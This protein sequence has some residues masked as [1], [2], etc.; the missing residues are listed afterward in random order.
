MAEMGL[1]KRVLIYRLGSL[2]DT[3]V[4]LPALHLVARAFP[5]AERRMLTNFPVNVKAPAA[6]A[7]LGD[8]GLVDGY[9]RYAVGTRS[10][11]ELAGLWW[12][13]RRWRPDVLVY[14]GAS[15]GWSRR[16]GMRGS[17]GCAGSDDDRCAADGG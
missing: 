9:F 17:S 3:L 8:S 15:R 2:G 11:R 16:G 13:L 14:L 12:Q 6:A 5:D 4:A 1:A 7:V 10:V